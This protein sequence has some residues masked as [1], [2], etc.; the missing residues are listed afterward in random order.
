LLR[1]GCHRAQGNLL[2][3]AFPAE[4]LAPIL[5]GQRLNVEVLES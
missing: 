4:Q 3:H 1:I 2:G 5:A